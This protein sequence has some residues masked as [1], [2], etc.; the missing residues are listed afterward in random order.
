M[1]GSTA[2]PVHAVRRTSIRHSS[3]ANQ[4]VSY[5]PTLSL[6]CG[7]EGMRKPNGPFSIHRKLT[8]FVHS[9]GVGRIKKMPPLYF[10]GAGKNSEK[11]LRSST[12]DLFRKN[13]QGHVRHSIRSNPAVRSPGTR[14]RNCPLNSPTHRNKHVDSDPTWLPDATSTHFVASG[15]S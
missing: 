12:M 10:L 1:Y 6:I 15:E 7:A 13:S 3:E 14:R 9:S 8:P 4:S 5:A 11:S 2:A